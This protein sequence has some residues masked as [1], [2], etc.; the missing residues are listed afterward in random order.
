MNAA[1]AVAAVI[2]AYGRPVGAAERAALSAALGYVRPVEGRLSTREIGG[3]IV[4]DDTYNA[5]PRSVR[6]ALAAARETAEALGA[7]LLVALGDMLELGALSAAMH[8][9]I[10]RDVN[11]AR[12]AALVAVG[13]E[14]AAAINRDTH[15]PAVLIRL[16]AD[17]AAAAAV[18]RE[19]V[20]PGDVLLVKGSRGIVMERIIEGLTASLDAT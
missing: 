16:A 20:R 1:A 15:D 11:R 3:V 17:S 18:V 6:A 5:N 7:R 2:A 13:P 9:E 10:V 14:M 4:I 12:P 19:I 8:A